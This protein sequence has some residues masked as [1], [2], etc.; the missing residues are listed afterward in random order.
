MEQSNKVRKERKAIKQD[1]KQ[2]ELESKM[3]VKA[4]PIYDENNV[5]DI[6]FK[7][8]NPFENDVIEIERTRK[9]TLIENTDYDRPDLRDYY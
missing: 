1:A 7:K 8:L 5:K 2:A 4:T 3:E 6:N 9:N